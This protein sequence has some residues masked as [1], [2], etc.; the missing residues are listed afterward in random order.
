MKTIDFRWRW[1]SLTTSTVGYSSDSWA[2][3]WFRAESQRASVI[4]SLFIESLVHRHLSTTSSLPE[5]RC[6]L[7]DGHARC[8]L[9]TWPPAPPALLGLCIYSLYIRVVGGLM[10]WAEATDALLRAS[11]HWLSDDARRRCE[12]RHVSSRRWLALP[13]HQLPALPRAQNRFSSSPA[14]LR[15][16]LE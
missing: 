6:R 10:L 15:T 3:C 4:T 2:S 16:R 5:V 14:T 11:V 12:H 8:G 7:P 9:P 13:P 1:R